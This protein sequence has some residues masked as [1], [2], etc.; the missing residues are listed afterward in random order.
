MS[1][2]S[3]KERSGTSALDEVGAAMKREGRQA[4]DEARE[5]VQRVV[6]DQRDALA[7]YVIALAEAAGRGAEGLESS[8]YPRSASTLART[9]DEVGGLAR[10]LQERAPGELWDDV[11]DFA[12][13][14]PALV[15]GAGLALAFGMT[16]FLKS[17][18]EDETEEAGA[19][20]FSSS[21]TPASA[22]TGSTPGS[23]AP[24][25]A[26]PSSYPP[27]GPPPSGPAGPAASGSDD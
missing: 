17:T 12:R 19:E 22:T 1:N 25:S 16:R 18:A 26:T 14:H 7:D 21:T 5:V 10:R 9:A 27:A 8:G 6:R 23:T 4:A 13:D 3:P 11:E 20:E 2:S 15:F 24:G